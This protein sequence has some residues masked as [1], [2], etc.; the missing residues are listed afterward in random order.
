MSSRRARAVWAMAVVLALSP[1]CRWTKEGRRTRHLAQAE[2]HFEQ[3][4]FPEA[5][6]RPREQNKL[7]PRE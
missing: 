5:V 7:F 1:A 2:A 6:Q 3:K 4:R